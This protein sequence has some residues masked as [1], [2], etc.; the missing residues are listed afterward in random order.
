[1]ISVVTNGRRIYVANFLCG[2]HDER[3][4]GPLLHFFSPFRNNFF[5]LIIKNRLN[6]A[7]NFVFTYHDKYYSYLKFEKQVSKVSQ[8]ELF[9]VNLQKVLYFWYEC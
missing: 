1:M 4:Q 6:I 2:P 3:V 9:S 8:M 7:S 5:M